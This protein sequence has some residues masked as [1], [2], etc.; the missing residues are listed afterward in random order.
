MSIRTRFLMV[1]SLMISGGVYGMQQSL[2]N[3]HDSRILRFYTDPDSWDL[4]SNSWNKEV[5]V[6]GRVCTQ[7]EVL[8]INMIRR[9]NIFILDA[10][11]KKNII[12]IDG[13]LGGFSLLHIALDARQEAVVAYLVHKGANINVVSKI[14]YALDP[15][16][17]MYN[18][19]A[20]T[21]AYD[22]GA[23]VDIKALLTQKF[24][25]SLGLEQ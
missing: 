16:R 5:V 1:L 14:T 6:K 15:D 21:Y 2:H 19:D 17:K 22:C 10:M 25:N 20:L 4:T 8:A 18:I 7:K 12:S 3:I 13:L 23:S 9:G 11:I 24:V